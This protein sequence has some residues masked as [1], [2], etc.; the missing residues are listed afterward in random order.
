MNGFEIRC[1]VTFSQVESDEIGAISKIRVGHDDAGFGAA[2][3]LEKVSF[4]KSPIHY[5]LP[6]L[7]LFGTVTIGE[8]N[9]V[10]LKV[11]TILICQQD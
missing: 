3:H 1:Q 7:G 6:A 5:N 4:S 11:C 9:S 8:R 10:M 2:W